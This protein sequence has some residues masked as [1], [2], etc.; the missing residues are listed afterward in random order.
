MGLL[1]SWDIHLVCGLAF[2]LIDE[3]HSTLAA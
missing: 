3:Q 1:Q 2:A